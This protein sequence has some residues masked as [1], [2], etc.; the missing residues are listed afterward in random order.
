MRRG[1][2]LNPDQAQFHWVQPI[3]YYE[4]GMQILEYKNQNIKNWLIFS[5]DTIW[6]SQ[7]FTKKNIMILTGMNELETLYCMIKCKG[8]AVISNSTFSWW[9]SYLNT[10]PSKLVI[11]PKKWVNATWKN[12]IYYKGSIVLE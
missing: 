5:D 7:S 6:C 11:F 10:N 2:F 9:G 1:D 3:E 4:L 12:D 8:G